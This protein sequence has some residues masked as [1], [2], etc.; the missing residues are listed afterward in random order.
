MHDLFLSGQTNSAFN[1]LTNTDA[2]AWVWPQHLTGRWCI[3]ELVD[4]I[5]TQTIGWQQPE[6][7]VYNQRFL[8][9]RL[10]A[11]FADNGLQYRYS[12]ITH[13]GMGWPETLQPLLQTANQLVAQYNL[14]PF[15]S[16]LLNYYRDGQ[17]SMGWHSDDER[18][19]GDNPAVLSISF[20]GTRR[21]R[22]RHKVKAYKPISLDIADGDVMLLTS[23]C[24]RFW[25]HC[26]T[27]TNRT[28]APRLNLTFR[29][30]VDS[31]VTISS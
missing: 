20:G 1:V 28:V 10:V 23:S 7:M 18:E 22:L 2:E 30:I 3:T 15:N 24:Q 29:R 8:T 9:P 16:V 12:G 11:F 25:Q 14:E 27:K 21:F 31:E 5:T 26:I 4:A 17:D 13:N 6:V 19:L